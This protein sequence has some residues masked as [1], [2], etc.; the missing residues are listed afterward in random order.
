VVW[1]SYDSSAQR[2]RVFL[3]SSGVGAAKI[4]DSRDDQFFPAVAPN[5]TGGTYVSFS[6]TNRTNGTYD[7]YLWDGSGVTKISTVWSVPDSD[8]FF[9]GQF[10]GDYNGMAVL[11]GTP[12]PTWTDIRG[13]NPSYPGYEMDAMSYSL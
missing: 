13:P 6:Q 5:S 3:W 12:Y 11:A 8:A 1:T 7:Q 2:G 10:I 9:S 4:V